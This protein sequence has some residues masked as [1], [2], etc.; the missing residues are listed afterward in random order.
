MTVA[1][2]VQVEVIQYGPS[3]GE[4]IL[5]AMTIVATLI[6]GV[7]LLGPIAKALARR[8]EGKHSSQAMQDEI[9]A[10]RDRVGEVDTL[11]ERVMEL[12]ERVD[13]TERMLAKAPDQAQLPAP[14]RS[15]R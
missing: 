11:R 1:S 9:D 5:I 4:S 12:E 15:E 6:G 3:V 14:G 2:I 10:L 8:L 7:Y 13:F